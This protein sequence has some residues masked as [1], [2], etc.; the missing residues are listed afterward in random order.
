MLALILNQL[1]RRN[2]DDKTA[3]LLRGQLHVSEKKESAT[4]LKKGDEPPQCHSD[5]TGDTADRI[6]KMTGVSRRT[7]LRD[8]KLAQSAEELDIAAD[9]I[10]GKCRPSAGRALEVR[11][12]HRRRGADGEK[13]LAL[14]LG[15]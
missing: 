6:A 3:S 12:H 2:V 14:C 7:V 13:P 5:T 15:H 11:A 9:I 1:G 4:T 8:A 10:A